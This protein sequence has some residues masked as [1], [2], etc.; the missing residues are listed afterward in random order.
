MN[1]NYDEEIFE[2][3]EEDIEDCELEATMEEFLERYDVDDLIQIAKKLDIITFHT[4]DEDDIIKLISQEDESK[5]EKVCFELFGD[6]YEDFAD[7]YEVNNRWRY[8]DYESKD[9]GDWDVDD[10]MA[11]AW[12]DAMEK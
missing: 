8:S 10:H 11:A 6:S 3:L 4:D 5:I 9:I 2:G 12:D 1:D 7:D